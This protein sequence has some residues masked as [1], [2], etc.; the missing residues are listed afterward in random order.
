MQRPNKADFEFEPAGAY[1]A[2]LQAWDTAANDEVAA[3]LREELTQDPA[4]DNTRPIS[5]T[6]FDPAKW[7]NIPPREWLYGGHY[8]RSYVTGTSAPSKQGKSTLH[9]A[10]AVSMMT[11]L[12]LLRV[13]SRPHAQAQAQ[14]VGLE[15]RGPGG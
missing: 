2:A 9:L 15:W 1:D 11:G 7:F 4:N 5:A 3:R 8:I 13:R 10:E 14:G 6:P 12:D